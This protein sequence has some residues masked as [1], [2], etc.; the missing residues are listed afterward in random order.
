MIDKKLLTYA[1]E[2]KSE[3]FLAVVFK[4]ILFSLNVA[5][6]VSA[7]WMI[8]QIFRE[9]IVDKKELFIFAFIVVSIAIL[10]VI[11]HRISSTNGFVIATKVQTK[12]RKKIYDKTLELELGYLEKSG[13][14]SL[15]SLSVEGVEMLEVYFA[16]YLPQLFYSLTVPFLLFTILMNIDITSPLVMLLSVP[17][18]PISIIFFMKSAK[19]T[20]VKF[21]GSYEALSGEFL[22]NIQGLVTLKL[23]SK[24]R[25]KSDE[26]KSNSEQFRQNTM[27]VLS[28][29]LFSIFI[30]DFF[31]LV[32]ASAGILIAIHGFA[33]NQIS[34]SDTIVII[35]LSSEFFLPMRML[36]ALFHAGMN[37]V[38]AFGNI[39]RFLSEKGEISQD[40]GEKLGEI[41]SL[42]W[43]NVTFSYDEK[44]SVLKNISFD[45]KKGEKIAIV[46]KS[47]SGKSTIGSILL[48]FFDVKRGTV[49]INN[50]QTSSID[51][52]SLRDSIAVVSQHTY[53]F[54][55]TI[56]ENL[57]LAKEDATE[58][59][60]LHALKVAGLEKFIVSL[61][62]G[63]DAKT[64][65]WGKLFSG[66]QKQRIALARAILKESS[67]YIFDEATSNVDADN[68]AEIWKNIFEMAKERTAIIISHRLTT[69][70][71][72]DR[73]LLLDDGELVEVGTHNELIEQDRIYASMYK[74][75]S[76]I[77]A[78]GGEK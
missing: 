22:E 75:Q 72:V 60:M 31:S 45:I 19:K 18:I 63:L 21:W 4:Y 56:R 9:R 61:P 14:S 42:S 29:Q 17:L 69:L 27:K 73:I 49:Q 52:K 78:V 66:G 67:F 13:T 58:E 76:N 46:G 54:D 77:E 57:R 33:N 7:S 53:V 20:M 15:V 39:S 32:G 24:D 8:D 10:R 2:V 38:A 16:R 74:E 55:S 51:I 62:D 48:R 68:E 12:I 36:G 40:D 47:G 50:K 35:M 71:H 28:M 11:V 5:L 64:G 34:F 30:M 44:R 1:K 23:Y 37:G 3:L 41:E 43:E 70:Q 65:E 26:M 6:I 59:E 25:E